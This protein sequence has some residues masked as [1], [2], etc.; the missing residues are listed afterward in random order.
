MDRNELKTALKDVLQ[1][2][3]GPIIRK[4]LLSQAMNLMKSYDGL[5]S[6]I[7]FFNPAMSSLQLSVSASKQT[8]QL[9]MVEPIDK[10]N[11][12]MPKQG[13]KRY[14]HDKPFNFALTITIS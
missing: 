7:T 8:F 6:P 14:K 11:R 13:E 5:L 9:Y 4:E 2:E 12:T 10:S 1:A 3:L